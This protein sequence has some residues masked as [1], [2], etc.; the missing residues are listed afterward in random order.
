MV[1]TDLARRRILY[2]R[3]GGH[4]LK[5]A[6][7]AALDDLLPRFVVP[8]LERPPLEPAALFQRPM[9]AFWLEVG[10]G[11]GEHLAEQAAQHPDVGCIGCEPF[12]NG[13][14]ML[15]RH[16]GELGLDNIRVYTDDARQL[17]DALPDGVIERV[18][19]LFPDPWPK[20]RH[21]RRRFIS[22]ETIVAL[23]RVMDRGAELRIATDH[24]E[25]GRWMLWH[26]LQCSAFE[27][28]AE[29]PSD[30][31]ERPRDETPT[32]YEQ[33]ALTAGRPCLYFRFRR[34]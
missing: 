29:Q 17:L 23:A 26:M 22:P 33:K 27:W 11:N 3:R 31:R 14:S 1:G 20:L 24:M 2:G 6:R 8:A 30:W 34:R 4:R 19:L 32:R 12:I 5:A 21:H 18:H 13:V 10:F 9:R 15:L 7:R 16:V 25:C 28:L